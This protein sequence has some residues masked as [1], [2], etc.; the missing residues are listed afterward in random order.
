[1]MGNFEIVGF[2]GL[3]VRGGLGLVPALVYD[4]SNKLYASISDARPHRWV[5]QEVILEA[6][7][8]GLV[9][10]F[11]RPLGQWSPEV[12]V[13]YIDSQHLATRWGGRILDQ[14]GAKALPLPSSWVW[15][16]ST[17]IAIERFETWATWFLEEAER[18][19]HRWDPH[20]AA[21]HFTA[22]IEEIDRASYCVS[23]VE[24]QPGSLARRAAVLLASTYLLAGK[25]EDERLWRDISF[26]F[27]PEEIR[28]IKSESFSKAVILRKP[29]S[30]WVTDSEDK[31]VEQPCI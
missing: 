16:E 29:S 28:R 2:D 31:R 21:S 9:T 10:L 12:C 24:E 23:T 4:S 1:M 25:F 26:D 17:H 3:P 22:A 11:P 19:V 15:C 8:K 18:L 27:E 5:K 14:I 30:R 7:E 13:A 20:A 6:V